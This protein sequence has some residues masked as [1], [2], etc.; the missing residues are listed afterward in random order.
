LDTNWIQNAPEIKSELEWAIDVIKSNRLYEVKIEYDTDSRKDMK[1]EQVNE[2][3]EVYTKPRRKSRMFTADEVFH[4]TKQR[5]GSILHTL[6]P[7]IH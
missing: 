2:I 4:L 1:S 5:E 6:T 7:E 3:L